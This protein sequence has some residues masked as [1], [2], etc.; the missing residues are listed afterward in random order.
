MKKQFRTFEDARK[1]V[2]T[3]DLKNQKEWR[4]FIK[5]S[6]RPND[7]PTN[8]EKV[9]KNKGWKSTGDW[10]GTGSIAT[11]YKKFRTFSEAKKFPHSLGIKKSKGMGGILQIW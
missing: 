11:F 7:I 4:V 5:S 1:Y 8:P 2:R 3:L 6:K 10:L 9:Y